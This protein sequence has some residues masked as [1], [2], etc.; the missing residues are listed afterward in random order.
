MSVA[1]FLC[2]FWV[3]LG[4][5]YSTVP[6][7]SVTVGHQDQKV[8]VGSSHSEPSWTKLYLKVP[9]IPLLDLIPESSLAPTWFWFQDVLLQM[10]ADSCSALIPTENRNS[11]QNKSTEGHWVFSHNT[12]K[13]QSD[14]CNR[15]WADVHDLIYS[16]YMCNLKKKS[17]VCACVCVC[18]TVY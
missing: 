16:I 11:L 6:Q 18:V 5:Y 2:V 15:L 17:S 4:S 8:S 13:G 1:L 9:L 12:L 3:S 10:D 7:L 14:V